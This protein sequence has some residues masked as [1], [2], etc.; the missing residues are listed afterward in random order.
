MTDIELIKKQAEKIF[1]LEEK[2]KALE[3]AETR[4]CD[5]ARKIKAIEDEVSQC[6]Y[7]SATNFANKIKTILMSNKKH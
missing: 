7:D 6:Q 1:E 5:F 2:I 4:A 3:S